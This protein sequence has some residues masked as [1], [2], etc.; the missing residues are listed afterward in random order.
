MV[1][2]ARLPSRE[3]AVSARDKARQKK[4]RRYL[5]SAEHQMNTYDSA[6]SSASSRF[7]LHKAERFLNKARSYGANVDEL[8]ERLDNLSSGT[9]S[10]Q[11]D[12]R[13]VEDI[14]WIDGFKISRER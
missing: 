7:Y 10:R 3:D 5:S 8:W 6:D 4:A 13:Q 11:E 12:V 9:T 14:H 1:S 2:S